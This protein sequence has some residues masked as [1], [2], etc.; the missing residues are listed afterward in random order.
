MHKARERL[1]LG[2]ETRRIGAL[3]VTENLHGD[4]PIEPDVER[5]VDGPHAA[6]SEQPLEA[7][8]TLE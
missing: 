7:V 3:G 4:G 8:S 1:H 5:P 6:A 2:F